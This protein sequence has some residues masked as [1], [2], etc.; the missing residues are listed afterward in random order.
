[1]ADFT[2]AA[3]GNLN[4]VLG[5]IGTVGTLMPGLFGNGILNNG[6]YNR[7][8][9]YDAVC[10]EDKPISRYEAGL[11]QQLTASE[12]ERA[13][14]K[15]NVYTDG[16]FVDVVNDYTAKIAALAAEVRGNK[17]EQTA[18][19][20]QQAVYNGTMTATVGCIQ[21][22]VAQ[23]LGLTKLVV[24]NSSVCPGWGNVTIT[25]ST[26]TTTA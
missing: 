5:A 15:S 3:Q 19:N 16:K 18:I 7:T 10:S 25:P 4:T 12:N 1:M 22:Q 24:P 20:T 11:L 6:C 8:G 2:P 13:I 17:D 23:L 21:G 26:T 14:L 9:C